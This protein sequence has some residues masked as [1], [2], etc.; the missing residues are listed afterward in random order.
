ML[1]ATALCYF[2][3]PGSFQNSTAFSM[4]IAMDGFTI[5]TLLIEP[6]I[7]ETLDK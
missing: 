6:D 1:R 4:M 2:Y 5:V 7:R 3:R